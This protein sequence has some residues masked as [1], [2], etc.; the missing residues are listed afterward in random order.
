MRNK[1]ISL[2]IGLAI[3]VLFTFLGYHYIER[4]N[5]NDYVKP[6]SRFYDTLEILQN[7]YDD[8]KLITQPDRVSNARTALVAIDDASIDEIG[9]WPWSR[10]TIYQITKELLRN[11]VRHVAFDVVF[12][13]PEKENPKADQMLGGLVAQYPE[14]IILGTAAVTQ[15]SPLSPPYQD[16][17]RVEAFLHFGGDAVVKPNLSFVVDDE[18]ENFETYNWRLLFNTVFKS[19]AEVSKKDF[20][21]QYHLKH[22]QALTVFQKNA[23]A[24]K[25]VRDANKYCDNWLTEQDLFLTGNSERDIEALYSDVIG[26]SVNRAALDAEFAKIKQIDPHPIPQYTDWLSNVPSVQTPSEYTAGFN[27]VFDSS[28][29]IRYYH[30][31]SRIGF[32]IGSSYIPSLAAQMYLLSEKRRAEILI[33]DSKARHEKYIK[34]FVLADVNEQRP[35]LK[36]NADRFARIRLNYVGRMNSFYYI[37]A[38]DLLHESENITARIRVNGRTEEQTFKR[39]EFLNDRSVLVGASAIGIGDIRNTPV[40]VAMPGPEIHLHAYANLIDGDFITDIENAETIIPV[41]TLIAGIILSLLWTFS[42]S[43]ISPLIFVI[44]MGGFYGIDFLFF[45]N[46]KIM[47]TTWPLYAVTIFSFAGILLFKYFSEERSKQKIR[48][49]FAKY[50]SPAVVDELLKSDKNLALGGKKQRLTVV[51]ADLR[52]FTTLS[53]QLTPDRLSEFLRAYFTMMTAEVFRHK[54]T[55][56]KFIGDAVMA[57]FGAP[58]S[59]RNNAENACLCALESMQKLEELNQ[60]FQAQGFPQ[61]QMGIGINT[62]EMSVGNMGSETL[63]NYTV[64]GDSVNLASRLESLNKEYGTSILIGPETRNEIGGL[65]VCREI[66]RVTVKGKTETITIHELIARTPASEITAAWLQAYTQ[67]RALYLER[68]FAE[69]K[70]AF[71]KCILLNSQDRTSLVFADRCRSYIET[72]PAADWNGVHHFDRI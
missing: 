28:G 26:R 54:G 37:S 60:N 5:Q 70:T 61:L 67:A 59:Y 30:L 51:F 55:L 25:T 49:A 38:K 19:L 44:V 62:G 9:R 17:C 50:V 43:L 13:E 16:I 72:P 69:A 11:G 24:R 68:S 64:V 63:Q 22:D 18:S 52:G 3:S 6:A 57:F 10:E 32:K 39:K 23:L 35:P 40:Q 14:R 8:V 31:F 42:S 4:M 34:E 47:A 1:A 2:L 66:D 53:E 41:L 65:F 45:Y 71:E 58:L 36:L 27:A 46:E 56:D 15:V 48:K 20:F 33:A 21:E 29:L 7:R 12:S